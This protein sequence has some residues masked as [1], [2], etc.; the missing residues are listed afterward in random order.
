MQD[1]SGIVLFS[2]CFYMPNFENDVDVCDEENGRRRERNAQQRWYLHSRAASLRSRHHIN[3]THDEFPFQVFHARKRSTSPFTDLDGSLVESRS[4]GLRTGRKRLKKWDPDVIWEIRDMSQVK[5]RRNLEHYWFS[6][7]LSIF[8][9]M[10]T[11]KWPSHT[12]YSE[13]IDLYRPFCLN[14]LFLLHVLSFVTRFS[15]PILHSIFLA[16]P[17]ALTPRIFLFYL[18]C[19]FCIAYTQPRWLEIK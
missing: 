8:L 9:D 18:S 2:F 14:F 13:M 11:Q 12:E 5:P 16:F 17:P 6:S 3:D 15:L 1:V 4:H 19:I 10:K 7:F